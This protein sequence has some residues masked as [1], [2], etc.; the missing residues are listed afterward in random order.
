MR[1][2]RA[3]V[4]FPWAGIQDDIYEFEV[5]DDATEEEINKEANEVINEMVWNRISSGWEEV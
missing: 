2:I 4:Q 1:K 3:Y 5:E